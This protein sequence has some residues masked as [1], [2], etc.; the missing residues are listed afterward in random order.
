MGNYLFKLVYIDSAKSVRKIAMAKTFN[1]MSP[2]EIV[3][4][5][6]KVTG[7][8][9]LHVLATQVQEFKQLQFK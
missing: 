7:D 5:A 1:A 2:A 3:D 4:L 9:K 8:Q 6:G